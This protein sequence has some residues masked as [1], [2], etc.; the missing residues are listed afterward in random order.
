[1]S[2]SS[3]LKTTNELM[4][5]LAELEFESVREDAP[6]YLVLAREAGKWV[7][8]LADVVKHPNGDCAIRALAVG[9]RAKLD[10]ALRACHA[11]ALGPERC[12]VLPSGKL[13]RE[14]PPP[15]KRS[16]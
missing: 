3:G 10:E 11:D 4:R 1:M 8:R 6:V 15:S 14:T 16:A 9:K 7:V 12:R 2:W 5:L 13:S